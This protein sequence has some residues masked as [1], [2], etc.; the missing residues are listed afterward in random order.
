M[1]FEGHFGDQLTVVSLYAQLTR[2]LPAIAK[3]LVDTL[4][5]SRYLFLSYTLFFLQGVKPYTIRYDTI[6]CI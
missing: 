4:I 2:D 5:R 6:V 3:F 1:T